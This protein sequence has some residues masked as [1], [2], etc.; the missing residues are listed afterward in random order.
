MLVSLWSINIK[1]N[2]I[3]INVIKLITYEVKLN[4][5]IRF[6]VFHRTTHTER[7]VRSVI[8]LF[9]MLFC[10]VATHFNG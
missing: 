2:K 9:F 10:F 1:K 3:K 7:H 6:K 4:V 5:N 8:S